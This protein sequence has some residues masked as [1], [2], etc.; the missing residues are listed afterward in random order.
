MPSSEQNQTPSN[1]SQPVQ[2]QQTTDSQTNSAVSSSST[3]RKSEKSQ[4]QPQLPKSKTKKTIFWLLGIL[5]LIL[6]AGLVYLFVQSY[7]LRQS[8]K[9]V[10][11][12][13]ENE[14]Q[15]P[16]QTPTV[17]P[18]LPAANQPEQ[19]PTVEPTTS[20]A[21]S[22][23]EFSNAEYDLTFSYPNNFRARDFVGADYYWL[24]DPVSFGVL[25]VQDVYQHLAQTPAIQVRIIETDK[26]VE[27]VI[28]QLQQSVTEAAEAMEDPDSMYYGVDTEPPQINNIETVDWGELEAV[29]VERYRGPG[30]P[31]NN[32]V[33]YFIKQDDKLYVFSANYGTYVPDVDQDGTVEKELVDDIAQTLEV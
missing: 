9:Q 6:I 30:A 15:Q 2:S 29:K 13:V 3:S 25:L 8:L 10:Q 33:E 20:A 23:Q 22:W 24:D 28:A 27:Q 11:Q 18:S 7:R 5:I 26:T 31:N 17:Q 14:S 4:R 12:E 16:T 21:Q 19:E 1:Q 32:L